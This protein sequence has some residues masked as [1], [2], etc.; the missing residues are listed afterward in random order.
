[1]SV[2]CARRDVRGTLAPGC[3]WGTRA[4]GL[5]HPRQRPPAIISA[6][7]SG[8]EHEGVGLRL[9]RRPS[10]PK[11]RR[12]RA[13]ADTT[14]SPA[15]PHPQE[16]RQIKPRQGRNRLSRWA[17][18]RTRQAPGARTPR[19][20]RSR[21][22]SHVHPSPHEQGPT[23][24]SDDTSKDGVNHQHIVGQG[25]RSRLLGGRCARR[26]DR[27]PLSSAT[28][29]GSSA[30]C[31]EVVAPGQTRR[32]L[33]LR[34]APRNWSAQRGLRVRWSTRSLLLSQSC[35]RFTASSTCRASR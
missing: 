33:G 12:A 27:E 15:R 13:V 25:S 18:A 31:V 17:L 22:A 28:N 3:P 20:S 35:P 26:T 8:L 32:I 6:P 4:G 21:R 1:M 14:R 2:G 24:R 34:V 9:A 10:G 16:T 5:S 23:R 29:F 11:R 30:L 19:T 7:L